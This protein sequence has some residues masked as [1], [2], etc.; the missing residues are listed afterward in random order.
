[1]KSAP[2]EPHEEVQTGAAGSGH[3]GPPDW[4]LHATA[5]CT[6]TRDDRHS[7]RQSPPPPTGRRPCLRRTSSSHQDSWKGDRCRP[8]HSDSTSYPRRGPAKHRCSRRSP[9]RSSSSALERSTQRGHRGRSCWPW[10]TNR[11]PWPRR[12]RCFPCSSWGKRMSIHST[13][14]RQYKPGEGPGDRSWHQ[15]ARPSHPASM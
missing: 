6:R 11:G 1:M 2:V 5:S 4:S 9:S 12:R 13:L 14:C 15:M 8:R 3:K 7:R 10:A